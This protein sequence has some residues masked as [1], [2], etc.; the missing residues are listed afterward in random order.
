MKVPSPRHV[1]LAT[2]ILRLS[3]GAV[4]IVHGWQK[5]QS[6]A[7]WIGYVDQLGWPLPSL[8]GWY[9]ILLEFV[10]G[11]MLVAGWWVRRV[12]LLLILEFLYIVLL[13][14]GFGSFSKVQVDLLM[15]GGSWA[16]ANLGE[17]SYSLAAKVRA[18]RTEA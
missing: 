18:K 10:G 2:L 7:G 15:L 17:G 14:K 12:S 4:L 16:L 6:P 3:V 11:L 13:V 5:L 9:I 1:D 8:F